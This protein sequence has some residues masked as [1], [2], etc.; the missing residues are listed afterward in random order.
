VDFIFDLGRVVLEW[1]H[2]AIVDEMFADEATRARVLRG[3]FEH[4]DWI[5]L[6][7]GTM[8]Q[9]DALVR[10]AER[11]GLGNETLRSLMA[12]VADR[13][14]PVEEVILM[15]RGL[16]ALGHG[17]FCLSNIH[18]AVHEQLVSRHSFYGLFDGI[19]ISA[20]VHMVKPEP[21]IF[22]HTLEKY[23]LTAANTVFIDDSKA[24]CVTA[25]ALGIQAILF[26]GADDARREIQRRWGIALPS[27]R[28]ATNP[29]DLV[30]RSETKAPGA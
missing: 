8:N 21:E 4:E 14:V 10:F 6:D 17:V 7:R 23:G 26:V 22:I 25:A 5:A 3:V 2:K 11:T 30:A 20:Y 16:K 15:V 18:K 13:L 9:A 28:E 24:N 12:R 1:D 27:P 29:R 19:V